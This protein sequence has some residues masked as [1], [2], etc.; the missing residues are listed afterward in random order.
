MN[1]LI[2]SAILYDKQLSESA[3]ALKA[4]AVRMFT[5][6]WEKNYEKWLTNHSDIKGT[7]YALQKAE[8]SFFF[9][10]SKLLCVMKAFSEKCVFPVGVKQCH[11]GSSLSVRQARRKH[12][13]RG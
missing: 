7:L 2:V 3:E 9:N 10:T 1:V 11:G 6:F 5:K 4:K 12:R 13:C 8:Q